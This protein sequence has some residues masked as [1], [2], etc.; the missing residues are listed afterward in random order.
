MVCACRTRDER[1]RR[2]QEENGRPWSET[3]RRRV[4][5]RYAMG[6]TRHEHSMCFFGNRTYL[7]Y[8]VYYCSTTVNLWC[9]SF[10]L[11][12]YETRCLG[13]IGSA[14]RG[15]IATSAL[16]WIGRCPALGGSHLC[17]RLY[18]KESERAK[19]CVPAAKASKTTYVRTNF[20]TALGNDSRRFVRLLV[21]FVR[22]V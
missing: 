5:D 20:A 4:V 17:D 10:S 16:N 13:V 1:R 18:S 14:L 3:K 7:V 11:V 6:G 2:G 21:S 12:P 22:G 15:Q 8:Q 19:I 9:A